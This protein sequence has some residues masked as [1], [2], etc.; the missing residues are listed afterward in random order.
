MGV[1]HG[2]GGDGGERETVCSVIRDSLQCREYEAG[3]SVFLMVV[4]MVVVNTRP[5][6]R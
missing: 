6:S 5:T 2:G 3:L 4:V 1:V